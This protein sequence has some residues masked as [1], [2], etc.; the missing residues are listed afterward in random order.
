MC[1][2]RLSIESSLCRIRFFIE[3]SLQLILFMGDIWVIYSTERGGKISKLADMDTVENYE[4]KTLLYLVNP[5]VCKEK[6]K[7]KRKRA[8]DYIILRLRLA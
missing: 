7:S 8:M 6:K 5:T 2:T 1:R 3:A 4:L